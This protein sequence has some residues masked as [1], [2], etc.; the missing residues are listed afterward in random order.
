[1]IDCTLPSI[2]FSKHNGD[3]STQNT[4]VCSLNFAD[5][6]ILL[7]KDHD[8]VEYMARKLKEEHENW[9]LAINLEKT[10]YVFMGEGKEILKFDGGKKYSLVH[11]VLI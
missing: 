9:G 2:I 7:A 11:N 1:V 6:Q 5:E 3:V 8:D 10:K 4:Y